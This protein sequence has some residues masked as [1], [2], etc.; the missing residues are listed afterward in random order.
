MERTINDIIDSMSEKQKTVLYD[1][2]GN[3]LDGEAVPYFIRSRYYKQHKYSKEMRDVAEYLA[4]KASDE[5][6]KMIKLTR[7]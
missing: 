7:K 2:L 4:D 3:I 6:R 5:R 1:I